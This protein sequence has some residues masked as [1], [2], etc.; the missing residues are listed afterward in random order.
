[1]TPRRVLAAVALAAVAATRVEPYYLK[2]PFADR[3]A[4][5]KSVVPLPDSQWPQYPQFLAAV[6]A[7][8]APGD[9]IAIVIPPSAPREMYPHAYYRASYFLTGREVL[10]VTDPRTGEPIPANAQAARYVA[11]FG[12]APAP[13]ELLWKGEGGALYR[14]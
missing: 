2:M 1:M 12:D 4:L 5:A 14:R 7:R 9:S 6:R 11:A 13:G 8:T 3:D 10:P